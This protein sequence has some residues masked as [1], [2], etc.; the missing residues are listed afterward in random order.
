MFFNNQL[1]WIW[2]YPHDWN[3]YKVGMEKKYKEKLFIG[4]EKTIDGRLIVRVY[5]D[6]KED[7]Y[8][9]WEDKC[10]VELQNEWIG[11]YS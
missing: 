6:Y 9:A 8:V 10:L 4:Y 1:M 7:I 11:K 5:K 2:G 3:A